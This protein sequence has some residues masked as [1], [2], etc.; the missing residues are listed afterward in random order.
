[1]SQPAQGKPRRKSVQH[2]RQ[3][4]I[5][6]KGSQAGKARAGSTVNKGVHYATTGNRT[7]EPPRGSATAGIAEIA[8]VDATPA[9]TVVRGEGTGAGTYYYGDNQILLK[10]RP[11]KTSKKAF[12]F[13][14]GMQ[15]ALVGATVATAAVGLLPASAALAALT[16][17]MAPRFKKNNQD[18]VRSYTD[19]SVTPEGVQTTETFD[20]FAPSHSHGFIPVDDIASIRVYT[21]RPKNLK[22]QHSGVQIVRKDGSV[23]SLSMSRQTTDQQH[24]IEELA[25]NMGR[26]LDKP[27]EENQRIYHEDEIQQHAG[28][29]LAPTLLQTLRSKLKRGKQQ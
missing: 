17:N 22:E 19:E 2:E 3:S 5:V 16:A 1:M 26:I 24:L 29:F 25:Q 21:A 18:F 7:K 23:A 27:V 12:A 13:M 28:V 6:K 9:V 4:T 15:G 14:A 11:T 20:A 8:Q 10:S